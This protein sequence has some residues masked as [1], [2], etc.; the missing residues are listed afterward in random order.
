[1]VK[2]SLVK[3]DVIKP[4]Y[5]SER[6]SRIVLMCSSMEIATPTTTKVSTVF[7]I[8]RRYLDTNLS[9]LVVL[10]RSF[11]FLIVALV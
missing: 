10:R 7:F 3:I 6:P 8:P 4:S 2:A 1:M 5:S 9:F 11:S